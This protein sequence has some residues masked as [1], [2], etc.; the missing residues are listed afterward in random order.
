MQEIFTVP[1][2]HCPNAFGIAFKHTNNWKLTYSGDTMPCPQL[3][4]L[5]QGSDV[6]IHEATMEDELLDEARIKLH[7]TTSQ[8]IEMGKKMNAKFI[9]LTH[10]SQRYAKIPRINENFSQNVGIAFDN[11]QG[12]DE[13]SV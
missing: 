12:F 10:F 5:G 7:S 1:V 3:V 4:D 6:L 8:A 13:L 9:L 2:K 11:M